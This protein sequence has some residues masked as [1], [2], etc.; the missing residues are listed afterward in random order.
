M[1]RPMCL[2]LLLLSFHINSH[3]C[4]RKLGLAY[5][6][7]PVIVYI[8]WFPVIIFYGFMSQ[9]AKCVWMAYTASPSLVSVSYVRTQVHNRNPRCYYNHKILQQHKNQSWHAYRQLFYVNIIGLHTYGHYFILVNYSC[10]IFHLL[11]FVMLLNICFVNFGSTHDVMFIP[12]LH[13]ISVVHFQI[14][15]IICHFC[16]KPIVYFS[17]H[18]LTINLLSSLAW[19]Y[20]YGKLLIN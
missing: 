20:Q 15:N 8:M 18:S 19:P 5:L 16:S 9:H 11:V 12:K 13:Q 7:P 6:S 10:Q 2:I 3:A 1:P 17:N 14:H 4:Y